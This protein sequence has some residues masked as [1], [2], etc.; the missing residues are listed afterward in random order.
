MRWLPRKTT[1]LFSRH[2]IKNP[3]WICMW[4][5]MRPLTCTNVLALIWLFL[6]F[7]LLHSAGCSR[8]DMGWS[9]PWLWVSGACRVLGTVVW[10]VPSDAPCHR[11]CGESIHWQATVPQAQHW[12]EPGHRNKLRHQKHPYHLDFQKWGE[13]GDG[14][15]RCHR[16]HTGNDGGEV[17]VSHPQAVHHLL[18]G[19]NSANIKRY[20]D[21]IQYSWSVL[22]FIYFGHIDD[23]CCRHYQ[24][25]RL[26]TWK[27]TSWYAWYT[28]YIISLCE[29]MFAGMFVISPHTSGSSVTRFN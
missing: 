2:L 3:T 29:K 19:Q 15:R 25:R 16:Y 27:E 11:R 10:P 1:T 17:L 18:R 20:W 12:Q 13:E 4:Q 5:P 28:W 21:C 23:D 22:F 24:Y 14:D 9:R 8:V 26:Q 6:F 7:S